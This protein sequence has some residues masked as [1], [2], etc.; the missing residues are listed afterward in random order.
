MAA[1]FPQAAA[2]QENVTGPIEIP[3]HVLVRQTIDDTLHEAL[4]VDGAARRCSSASSRG[5]GARCTASTPPSR[6]CSRTRSSPPGRTRSS[7]T[8]SSRTGA[9]TRCTLRRGLSVDLASIGALDPDAIERVHGEIT[10]EPDDGRRPPRPAVLAGARPRRAPTGSALWDE[11]VD[12]RRAVRCS[13]TTASELWCTTERVDD[14]RA[15]ARRRRR[16]D[17][18]GRC[19]ATSSSPGSPPSTRS[20]R[21]PRSRRAGSPPG[22]PC[23]ST[24]GFAL[25][26]RYH[27]T[28]TTP[29]G[30]RAGCSRACT[31]TRG[32]P[33]AA[34]SSRSPRRTSCASCCAGSTSRPAP[35]SPARP[36]CST[37]LEQLQG[38]E[39]AAV[40]VG[41]R[42]ARRRGCGA[43]TRPGSTGSATT[44]RS[45]GCGSRPRRATT[46][47]RPRARRRRPR[48]SRSC[49]APT[50]RGCS[51]RRAAA[52]IR[53]SR[54]SARPP[55]CSRCCA[56][57]G[58]CF[59]AELGAATGRLP[60]DIER[61]LWDGVARGL[62]TPT[63]SAPSAPRVDT[64]ARAPAPTPAGSRGC[65]AAR[66]HAAAA[67]GRW[68]LVPP[69]P[70]ADVD[71]DELAEAV[72]EQLLHRW[73]VRVP[74]PRG[75]RLAALPVARPPVGA[76][77]ARR[78]RAGARRPLRQ[79]LQRRAVRAAR[80]GRAAHARAQARRAPASGSPSTPPIR[81]TSSA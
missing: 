65:A 55:R 53:A 36:G 62:V 67:A 4:D 71:R 14:A 16:R 7:T 57:A 77:P 61:A 6:R 69:T 30:W 33:G 11:L 64:A 49:S 74:R 48:R 40:G 28:P 19:A 66:A 29:S 26:G 10:P 60:E 72:A 59:A 41:A 21:R 47:T 43:T 9:P 73:G 42:A 79:R 15:R 54:R 80:R 13:S 58:A 27:R 1:V 63:A 44:A 23:S 32:A 3:D 45:A 37:V 20:P 39:A 31:R 75:P 70:S 56:S 17:R 76:A 24:S 52:A 46:P 25:Q 5:D 50:C 38:F 18:R 2:C 78:P 12:A 34:A 51:T 81:S 35:S 68:S 22:S 8:R